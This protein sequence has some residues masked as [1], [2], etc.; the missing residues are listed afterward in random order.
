MQHEAIATGVG[1]RPEQVAAL[2]SGRTSGDEFDQRETLVL[3]FVS[4]VIDNRGAKTALVAEVE[5]ALSA[6]EVVELL[7]VISHYYGLALLLN[8]TGLEP[9]PPAA[10]AV[11][12][13]A[14]A[15]RDTRRSPTTG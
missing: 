4:E 1:V 3:R 10:M 13:A 6:R 15:N 8:T 7:L 14:E 2:V 5:E 11:V 12:E 9:D